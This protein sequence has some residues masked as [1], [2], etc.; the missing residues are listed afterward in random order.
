[1]WI[2]YIKLPR[3]TLPRIKTQTINSIKTHKLAEKIVWS[4]LLSVA[5]YEGAREAIPP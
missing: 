5:I 4:K 2:F 3:T 1:M